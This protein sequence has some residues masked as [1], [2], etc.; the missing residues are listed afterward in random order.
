MKTKL[1][2]LFLLMMGMTFFVSCSKDDDD[3]DNGGSQVQNQFEKNYFSVEDGTFVNEDYPESNLNDVISDVS[4]NN[5]ALS[6]GMNYITIITERAYK[7]FFIAVQ[8]QPGYWVYYPKNVY[9]DGGVYT[10]IIVLRYSVDYRSNCILIVGGEY[11]DG[12]IPRYD[13]IPVNYVTSKSGDL[14][15][16][17]TFSNEKDVDLHLWTP[18]GRHIWYYNRG[19]SYYGLD[20]DSNAGCDIDGLNN[21]NIYIPSDYIEDG[22]YT[23]GVALYA[24]CDRSIST[25]WSIVARYKGDIIRPSSGKNPV[26]GVYPVGAYSEG[27]EAMG[28]MTFEI[29]NSGNSANRV[30]AYMLPEYVP[31][32][33]DE[34]K[35][36]ESEW[37]KLD[38]RH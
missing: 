23:V 31:T 18:S 35:H 32:D 24:N 25:R 12:G 26:S 4:T 11:E 5:Q 36:E 2:T 27:D 6:G 16:N 28:V 19:S 37:M 8:G 17:L 21:E 1:F 38:K 14:N 30:K 7:K 29:K 3:D 33:M 13:K 20:H 15:I 22:T 9:S 10:Y 34:M